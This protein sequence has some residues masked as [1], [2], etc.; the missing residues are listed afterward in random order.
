MNLASLIASHPDTAPAILSANEVTTYGALRAQVAALRGGLAA[1]GVE[2]DDRVGLILAS[3]WYFVAAYLA[4]L[5]SGAIAVPLNPQSPTAELSA[6]LESRRQ[7]NE[8]TPSTAAER[9]DAH[10]T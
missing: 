6:E 5:G 7:G 9:G 3:N 4:V 8:E 1:L 2:P 10:P